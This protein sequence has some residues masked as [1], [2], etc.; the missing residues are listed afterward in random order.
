[1]HL[2]EAGNKVNI[3][4]SECRTYDDMT[5]MPYCLVFLAIACMLQT[6]TAALLF[7]G[8]TFYLQPY[9]VYNECG[10]QSLNALCCCHIYNF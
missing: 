1:M 8:R 3:Q 4:M 10:E 9:L 2:H 5:I 6:V 7:M